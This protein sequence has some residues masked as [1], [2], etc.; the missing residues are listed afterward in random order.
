MNFIDGGTGSGSYRRQ[1]F[2]AINIHY[3]LIQIHFLLI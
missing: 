3:K 2:I 1:N